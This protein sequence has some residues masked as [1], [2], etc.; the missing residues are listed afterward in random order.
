MLDPKFALLGAAIAFAGVFTYIW[1]TLRGKTQPNRVTWFLWAL[2]PMVAFVAQLGEGVT[3][4]SAL[5]F[6]SGF[7]PALVLAASFMDR[8]AYWKITWPDLLCGL[9]SVGAL[10]VW[11]SLRAGTLAIA[12]S[13]IGDAFAALPTILKS[14]RHPES[15]SANAFLTGVFAAILTLLTVSTW[16]FAN[17]G[18]ALY[19][20]VCDGLIFALV[21]FPRLRLSGTKA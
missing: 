17:Y 2:S 1:D 20:L 7:G 5:T 6:V 19:L 15:E 12:L 13:I 14:Y 11:L 21:R 8:R 16:T 18:F 4:Q 10:V 3:Y 9:I